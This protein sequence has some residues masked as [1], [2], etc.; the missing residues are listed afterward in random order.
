MFEAYLKRKE[1]KFEYYIVEIENS[2]IR[3]SN[4]KLFP[5]IKTI[6]KNTYVPIENNG[7]KNKIYFK[8]LNIFDELERQAGI[9]KS[10]DTLDEAMKFLIARVF[11]S[12]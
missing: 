7:E 4:V 2:S 12:E 9:R 3:I 10:F 6:I 5:Y 1:K 11:T 8:S